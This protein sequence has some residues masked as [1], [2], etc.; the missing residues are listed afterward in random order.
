MGCGVWWRGV[1]EW[2]GGNGGEVVVVEWCD[3][4]ERCDEWW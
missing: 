4:W 2:S 3:E 1:V